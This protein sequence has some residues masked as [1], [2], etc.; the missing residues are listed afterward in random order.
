M[1]EVLKYLNAN[2][3][4]FNVVFSGVVGAATV[5]YAILTW[6]IVT[7]TKKLRKVETDP[8]V[9]IYIEHDERWIQCIDLVVKNIGK[10]PA[11]AISFNIEPDFLMDASRN[12]YLSDISFMKEI[13]YLPPGNSLKTFLAMAPDVLERDSKERAFKISVSYKG[14]DE[15]EHEETYNIDFELLTGKERIGEHPLVK[16]SKEIEGVSSEIHA[17]GAQIKKLSKEKP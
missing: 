1:E 7:E 14:K 10:G 3:G 15:Q 9:A 5:F 8:L 16:I 2:S 12:K 17:L 11:Y 13:K 6:A 4:A